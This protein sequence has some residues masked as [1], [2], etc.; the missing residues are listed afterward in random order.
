MA[1]N[2]SIVEAIGTWFSGIITAG[3]LLF[4]YVQYHNDK[5]ERLENSNLDKEYHCIVEAIENISRVIY[6]RNSIMD[7]GSS[8]EEFDSS[9]GKQQQLVIKMIES[10]YLRDPIRATILEFKR[11]STYMQ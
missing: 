2:W 3:T 10:F 6:A 5:K 9:I 7:K 11:H 8:Q 1:I 4:M